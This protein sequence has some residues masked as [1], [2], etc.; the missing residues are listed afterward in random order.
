ML[1]C[2]NCLPDIVNGQTTTNN[3]PSVNAYLT[4]LGNANA[5]IDP[6]IYALLHQKIRQ[7]FLLR[8]KGITR[9]VTGSFTVSGDARVQSHGG[10]SRTTAANRGVTPAIMNSGINTS[11][12][13]V[14]SLARSRPSSRQHSKEFVAT[15]FGGVVGN[16]LTVPSAPPSTIPHITVDDGLEVK[17]GMANPAYTGNPNIVITTENEQSYNIYQVS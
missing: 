12:T 7:E 13:D 16:E 3:D 17:N 15:D 5:A 14:Q 4:W 6:I 11:Y 9:K 2:R 1:F 8:I 10:G